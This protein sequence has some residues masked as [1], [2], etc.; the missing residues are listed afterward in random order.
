MTKLSLVAT[1]IGN[2]ADITLRALE[3]LRQADAIAAEDTRHSRILLNHYQIEKPL[4][5]LDAH[6]ITERAPRLLTDYAHLAFITDA[7]TPG[8]SDPGAEL[9]RLALIRGDEL[10]L[11]PGATAF[12]P[13]LVLSGLD[14]SRF[15]F[16]G[17]LPRK[18]KERKDRLEVIA[19]ARATTL[20]YEA[21]NRL[22]KTLEDLQE[23]CGETREVSVSREL[24]KR[25][26]T[27]YRG[28]LKSVIAELS[29]AEIKG[30]IVVV[31]GPAKEVEQT[32]LEMQAQKLL[33]QGLTG[34]D[35]RKA[36]MALGAPRNEA[37]EL[38]LRLEQ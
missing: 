3:T 31:V 8:I 15:C 14:T 2:L 11:L 32:D 20:L 19:K 37:Y 16:E 5:R 10:E 9:V 30:E 17:F 36:L 7:G 26:E 24:T 29:Q 21:P 18:G 4:H 13:A 27:T 38:V 1:P 34:K 6:T 22:L 23:F 12:V 35:L 28:N 33:E 25:F